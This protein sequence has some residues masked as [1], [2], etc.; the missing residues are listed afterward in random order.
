MNVVHVFLSWLW[1]LLL[2]LAMEVNAISREQ[3]EMLLLL[4]FIT[5]KFPLQT[6]ADSCPRLLFMHGNCIPCI[7]AW[8]VSNAGLPF[9]FLKEN[10]K[11]RYVFWLWQENS[12]GAF[13]FKIFRKLMDNPLLIMMVLDLELHVQFPLLLLDSI[14]W[15]VR[16][17][18]W[19]SNMAECEAKWNVIKFNSV[20]TD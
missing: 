6:C 20:S 4:I 17:T 8:I 5:S 12:A 2:H 16:T 3:F 10:E 1:L 11:R 14:E 9:I 19:F 15:N 7:I 18:T 13:L